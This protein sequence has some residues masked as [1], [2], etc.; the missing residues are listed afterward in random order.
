MSAALQTWEH[1]GGEAHQL[2]HILHRAASAH[3]TCAVVAQGVVFQP[4]HFFASWGGVTI[5][6]SLVSLVG[7]FFANVVF[8]VRNEDTLAMTAILC[9]ELHS[10]VKGSPATC[11]KVEDN[12]R[13][14]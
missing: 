7:Y 8:V 4:R 1:I 14:R 9:I 2:A 6:Y 3:K 5:N 11:E 10:G 12:L 13:I